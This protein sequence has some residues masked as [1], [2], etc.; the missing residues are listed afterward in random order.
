MDPK[1]IELP[2]F[3]ICIINDYQDYLSKV[4]TEKIFF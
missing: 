3:H 2:E 1:K 4:E